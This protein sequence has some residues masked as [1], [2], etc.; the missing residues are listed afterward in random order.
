MQAGVGGLATWIE[1]EPPCRMLSRTEYRYEVRDLAKFEEHDAE[2]WQR[3]C[4]EDTRTNKRRYEVPASRGDH[5]RPLL[6]VF[7]DECSAQV[8]LLQGLIYGAGLRMWFFN[9]PFHRIWNDIKLALQEAG[10]WA[11]VYERLHCENLPCG[12]FKSASWWREMQEVMAHHFRV[13][14]KRNELFRIL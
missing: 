5:I 13:S 4:V 2:V 7:A 1:E 11:D 10:L 9:D 12:P 8:S 14:N 3:W 6:V